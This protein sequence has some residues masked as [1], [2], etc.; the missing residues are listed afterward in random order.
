MADVLIYRD[1][2]KKRRWFLLLQL[3]LG[4]RAE[5]QGLG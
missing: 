2:K 1:R 3:V 5:P 4:R